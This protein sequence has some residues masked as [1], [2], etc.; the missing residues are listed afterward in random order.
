M[1]SKEKHHLSCAPLRS[2]FH[3]I[4]VFFGVLKA[5]G[6]GPWFQPWPPIDKRR[7]PKTCELGVR[8]LV[9][10]SHK[11]ADELGCL[12]CPIILT[13]LWQSGRG[14]VSRIGFLVPRP[15]WEVE[16]TPVDVS[17][18]NET[19]WP[20]RKETGRCSISPGWL[21]WWIIINSYVSLFMTKTWPRLTTGT[22]CHL[23]EW[24]NGRVFWWKKGFH[25]DW[26]WFL[27]KL[28]FNVLFTGPH[29]G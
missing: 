7:R 3:T 16:K 26:D 5:W 27:M 10:A 22:F 18:G 14:L 13:C 25:C 4:V 2:N 12:L 21:D 15:F 11:D 1:P 20:I 29:R 28:L 24:N 17:M 8:R 19:Q 6:L 23:S 9:W